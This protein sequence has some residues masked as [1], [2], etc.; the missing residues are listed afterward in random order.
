MLVLSVKSG[1]PVHIGDNITVMLVARQNGGVR[2]AIEAPKDVRI[3]TD[4]NYK[5]LKEPKRDEPDP[6]HNFT[7]MVP[8]MRPSKS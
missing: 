6:I 2:I 1:E 4:K 3:L 7:P 8:A 5:K